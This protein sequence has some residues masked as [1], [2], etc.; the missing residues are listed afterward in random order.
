[1]IFQDILDDLR[2]FA[3][4]ESD[5]LSDASG[6]VFMR[7]NG[8]DVEFDL[9]ANATGGLPDVSCDGERM[10][11]VEFLG[12]HLANLPGFAEKIVTKRAPSLPAWIDGPAT[13]SDGMG[14]L[15]AGRSLELLA[16]L[17]DQPTWSTDLIFVTADAGHGKSSLLSKYQYESARGFSSGAS[18]L[19]WHIDLQGRQLLQLSEALMGDLGDLRVTG[20]WPEAI[21]RLV[22]RG[23][24]I[25]AVDGFDELAAERGDADALGA[26]AQVI[27]KLDGRGTVLAAS[28]S[29]FFDVDDYL[30]QGSLAA[31]HMGSCS[32]SRLHLEPW[33]REH[34]A[35]YL[36]ATSR[37]TSLLESRAEIHAM[38]ER[39]GLDGDET[40][41][42]LGRPFL[43][44]RV[45]KWAERYECPP[46]E[47]LQPTVE[48]M[49]SLDR[50]LNAFVEREVKE[51][52]K[53]QQ[54]GLPYLS[55]E[56]HVRFLEDVAYEM[57]LSQSETLRIDVIN[58]LM[59][60]LLDDWKVSEA[61]QTNVLEMTRAHVLL[62][63]PQGVPFEARAF[64]HPE[65]RHYF[66]AQRLARIA[67][68][69][70]ASG[71]DGLKSFLSR[72]P[73]PESVAAHATRKL[74]AGCRAE[75]P[76]LVCG[77]CGLTEYDE[78]GG[79]IRSNVGTLLPF[80]LHH[81]PTGGRLEVNARVTFTG[82][83]LEGLTL[84]NIDF[85]RV[86]LVKASL[87]DTH[88]EDV[89]F[90][91]ASI[92][93]LGVWVGDHATRVGDDVVLLKDCALKGVVV[94]SA[95]REEEEY[96]P[97]RVRSR[98]E[99]VGFRFEESDGEDEPSPPIENDNVKVAKKLLRVLSRSVFMTDRLI[100][101]RLSQPE[102]RRAFEVV[103]PLMVDHGILRPD[104][105][106]GGGG[107]EVWRLQ[108]L[109]SDVLRDEAA[110]GEFAGFWADLRERD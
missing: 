71:F 105:W 46:H 44:T 73:L 30:R 34:N 42:I 12:D 96:A 68:E 72:G 11:F 48:S 37:W 89:T 66:L 16:T 52:W 91:E 27:S 43:F 19:F 95:E 101:L 24:L 79:Y 90:G 69:S 3:D 102:P 45:V 100:R 108:V 84:R 57:W 33:E 25:L 78:R 81:C 17:C 93:G 60:L 62:V 54:T 29:A 40:H 13:A 49:D 53:V 94:S 20:L 103:L 67:E 77:L 50:V 63:R 21:Y 61:H 2:A 97:V 6:R 56:Q 88:L 58:L 23:L 10:P 39:L 98:L 104:H 4:D 5:F 107:G 99:A 64:D 7:R 41:P 75:L 31:A 15:D 76:D 70:V 110:S 82:R 28:R 59:G 86:N 35:D 51:K 109:V 47:L 9:I 85:R 106:Q 14:S 74:A 8:H 22:R 18:P 92:V 36:C 38:A 87:K 80:L 26:L 83:A 55:H 32:I 1:M 65:F